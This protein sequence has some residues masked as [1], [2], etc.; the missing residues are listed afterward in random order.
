MTEVEI[1]QPICAKHSSQPQ[2]GKLNKQQQQHILV[3]WLQEVDKEGDILEGKN[4][5]FIYHQQP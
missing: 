3:V 1:V 5:S 4:H 2:V